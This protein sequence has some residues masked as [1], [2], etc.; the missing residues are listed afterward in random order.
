MRTALVGVR[1][2]A[3]LVSATA[4]ALVAGGVCGVRGGDRIGGGRG[5]LAGAARGDAQFRRVGVG[6]GCCGQLCCRQGGQDDQCEVLHIHFSSCLCFGLSLASTSF[7]PAEAGTGDA[8]DS[9][10]GVSGAATG[11][12]AGWSDL[13]HGPSSSRRMFSPSFNVTIVPAGSVKMTSGIGVTDG[14]FHHFETVDQFCPT[15]GP[16]RRTA[17]R[18]P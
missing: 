13:T 14:D 16:R 5:A 6:V 8:V 17:R 2:A 3:S 15:S 4:G 7:P 10:A 11:T 9:S 1:S 12:G 18:R